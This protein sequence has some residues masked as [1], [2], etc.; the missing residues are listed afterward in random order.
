[1]IPKL[2]LEQSLQ[3][4]KF[5]DSW[6]QCVLANVFVT[7]VITTGLFHIQV[8]KSNNVC[9]IMYNLCH[10]Y[11]AL[12]SKMGSHRSY[13]HARLSTVVSLTLIW[14]HYSLPSIFKDLASITQ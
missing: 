6:H 2:D 13:D 5:Q 11:S 12:M 3:M 7:L 1:M 8:L 10:H 9:L 4:C 14:S